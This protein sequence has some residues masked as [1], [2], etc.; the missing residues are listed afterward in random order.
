MSASRSRSRSPRRRSR[1]P[2]EL[3]RNK[4]RGHY[5]RNGRGRRDDEARDRRRDDRVEHR[6]RTRDRRYRNDDR[7][8]PSHEERSPRR[9]YDDHREGPSSRPRSRQPSSRHSRSRS[10]SKS[11]DKT[12]PNFKPSGLLA[13]ETNTVARSDGTSTFLKYNEPPEARRPSQGWRLYV[14]KGKEQVGVC[15]RTHSLRCM[16]SNCFNQTYCIYT[17]KV[18]I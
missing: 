17:G 13:A 4:D 12:Q 10:R 14:F 9:R 7:G 5:S 18:C 2:E 11:V 16:W 3:P 1:Y 6:E 15:S 8:G